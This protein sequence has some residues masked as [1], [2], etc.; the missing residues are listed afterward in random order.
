[1]GKLVLQVGNLPSNRLALTNKVYLSTKVHSYLVQA[2]G[3]QGGG[4]GSGPLITVGP[5]VYVAEGNPAV[6]DDK[7]A[8]NGL[9]RRYAQLSLSNRVE[10]R[11]FL[12]P[13]NYALA[14][15]EIEVDLLQKKA[16]QPGAP[17]KDIDTDRLAADVLLNYEG[18]VF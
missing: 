3:D 7:I 10:I 11:P 14:T 17:P 15:L 6:P 18:H 1:M 16:A 12:P 13:P 9:Q 5:H 8:L 2:Q 4:G